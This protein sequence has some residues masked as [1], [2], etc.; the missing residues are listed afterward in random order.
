MNLLIISPSNR[1]N[2]KVV[3]SFRVPQ[4]GPH[5]LAALTPQDVSITV[6]DEEVRPIDPSLDFDLVGITAMTATA[7]RSY[8][9]AGIYRRRGSKVVLGGVHP[10]ILP[11]EAIQYADAVVIGE[12]E[13]CW[14][15][16]LADFRSNRLQRFY[17]AKVPDLSTCPLPKRD[18][19][20]DKTIFNCVAL[21]TTRG[22]PYSCEFCS[23]KAL[24]GSRVRHRPIARVLQDI[25]ESPSRTFLILD[26]NI[27]GHPQYSKQLFEAMIPLGIKWAGQ[28]SISLA[29]DREMLRLCRL[30]GCTA[31][32]F[33]VES[34]S[35]A[36]LAGLGKSAKSAEET[37]EAIRIIEDQGIAF[38]PS[39]IFGFDTDTKAVF[40]DTLEFLARAGVP[41]ATFNVL[42]PYPGTRTYERLKGEGRIICSDWSRY[43]NRTVVFKPTNMSPLELAEGHRYVRSEFYS[44]PSI[45]R[46]VRGLWRVSPRDFERC[47]VLMA[48]NLAGFY[49]ARHLDTS[50]SWA[51]D[52]QGEAIEQVVTEDGSSRIRKEIDSH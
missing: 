8:E 21:V 14:T 41:T 28:S 38:H 52:V 22:C 50:L 47:L 31:L 27:T 36:S 32:L 18:L 48:L 12:A 4:L 3:R 17:R 43:D 13:G 30:S 51:E 46:H 45:L 37:E 26:D 1:L 49:V 20:I 19:R 39:I 29:K 6:A 10:S 7:K 24:Y 11:E 9:L 33:G 15:D 44:L 25:K 42:T 35:P 2:R 5:I 40:D 23:V 16:V 34:V